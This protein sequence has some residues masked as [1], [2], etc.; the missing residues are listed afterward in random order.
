M[1]ISRSSYGKRVGIASSLLLLII[2][3]TL[4]QIRNSP[5]NRKLGVDG[6][7]FAYGGA[8]TLEGELLYRD[9]WDHKPPGIFYLNAAAFQLGGVDEWS[10]WYLT[11]VWAVLIAGSF[12]WLLARLISWPYAFLATAIFSATLMQEKFYGASNLTEYYGVLFSILALLFAHMYFSLPRLGYVVGLGAAFAAGALLKHTNV[13]TALVCI[14]V[15]LFV[16][17]RRRRAWHAVRAAFAF[18]VPL[19]IAASLVALYW[20][21]NGAFADLW[22]ATVDYNLLAVAGGF[23]LRTL[24]DTLRFIAVDFWLGPLFILAIGTALALW[25]SR[26]EWTPAL[27]RGSRDARWD[28]LPVQWTYAVCI[29]ALLME[30]VFIALAARGFAH[31]YMSLI[32][33]LSISTSYWLL[34]P[35]RSGD[36]A[37]SLPSSP[38]NSQLLV[39]ASLFVW[40]IVTFGLAHPSLDDIRSFVLDAP[41]RRTLRTEISR[42]ISEQTDPDDTVLA[43]DIGAENNFDSNR[44]APSRYI[45]YLPLFQPGYQNERRWAE[46]M[47][48]LEQSPPPLIIS[49]WQGGPAPR[50]DEPLEDLGAIC[51]CDGEILSGLRSFSEFIKSNY[52][53]EL[54]L[55]DSFAAYHLT[56]E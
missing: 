20:S 5:A 41:E 6:T 44:R 22:E 9:F 3:A 52:E 45:Y 43:W 49:R 55:E 26:R 30:I 42:Y 24:Y 29:G 54:I 17:V 10:I 14:S 48:D 38:S 37:G 53:R 28:P 2:I 12:F 34:F 27:A 31:Y 7:V 33:A 25:F 56:T 40:L 32:P 18:A 8:R 23:G 16:E 51:N 13:A 19:V 15:V 46:F 47:N 39:S 50:F 4:L 36:R 21:A 1:T 11:E 35:S